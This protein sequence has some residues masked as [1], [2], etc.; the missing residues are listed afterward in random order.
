M[1]NKN[2]ILRQMH[3]SKNIEDQLFWNSPVAENSV[4]KQRYANN[5]ASSRISSLKYAKSKII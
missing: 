5:R 1:L 2:L 3:K 4:M